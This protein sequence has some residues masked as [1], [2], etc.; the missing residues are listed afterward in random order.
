[1][2][3]LRGTGDARGALEAAKAAATAL[4]KDVQV[5][6]TL[7]ALQLANGET[8]QARTTFAQVAELQPGNPAATLRVAATHVAEKDFAGALELQRKVLA[9]QPNYGPAILALAATHIAAGKPDDAIAEAK[10]IQKER[11]NMALGYALESEVLASQKK[12]PEAAAAM[13]DALAKQPNPVLA[14]RQYA[15]LAASGKMGEANAFADKWN[16]EHAKDAAFLSLV[17]QQRQAAKDTAGATSAYRAALE[18]DPDNV[19]VLNNLAWMLNE[20]GKPEAL[21]LAERAHGLAPLNANVIDTHGTILIARGDTQRGLAMLK[22]ATHLAPG[23]SRL[24]LNYARALAKGGDKAG[25]KKELETLLARSPN[26]SKT[27][28]DAEAL[29]K[30]L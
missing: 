12:Y 28:T 24:R 22:Q 8:A 25:A 23:D 27:R 3:H 1:M 10:R 15:L 30:T 26:P 11:P 21:E 4:P 6:E 19:V 9:A 16:K 5:L 13:R 20:Q 17:G 18:I 29:L 14:A 2:A 7:G